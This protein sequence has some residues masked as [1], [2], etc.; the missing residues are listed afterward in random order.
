MNHK[1]RQLA[2]IRHE[3]PDRIPVDAQSIENLD[4]IG[5]RLGIPGTEVMEALG[6][7]G[8]CVG[9]RYAGIVGLDESGQ[10]LTEWGTPRYQ[11][12][13]SSHVYPLGNADSISEVERYAWPDPARY[14]CTAARDDAARFSGDYAVRGPRFSAITDPVCLLLGQEEALVKMVWNP[15][16]F[17][18]VVE[19]IFRIT[20]EA[21]RQYVKRFGDHLDSFCVWEDFATQRGM[22]F[23]P[24][25]WRRFFKPRYARLFEVVKSAGKT[26]WFHSCG[27]ITA[28]LPDLLDI[29]MD[30]WET[31]QLHTLPISPDTLK[32]E[33][34]RDLTFFGGVNTQR[35]P[36]M[37]P[38]EVA[39]EVKRCIRSLGKG[40]GFICGPDHH[41][42]PDVPAENT[43]ALFR[44]AREFK[45]QG[46]TG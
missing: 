22:L 14:D 1:E 33:Y 7:D 30:V 26:V 44:T 41:I 27:D 32:K 40:G 18:A 36:F 5:K 37:T 11:D 4:A 23:S 2:A 43:L 19:N 45:A 31:V 24:E 12:W 9:I 15:V 35:L 38:A 39:E 16:V 17:E 25:H 28:V 20:L 6:M 42:K 29:G 34:G 3:I 8:V 10:P 46:Y 21:T 13:G